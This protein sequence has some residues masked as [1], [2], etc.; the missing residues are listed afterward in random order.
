M[1]WL[2]AESAWSDLSRPD[3]D[4]LNPPNGVITSSASNVLTHTV[5]ARSCFAI[6]W[7]LPTLLV[8]TEA[9]NPYSVPF[10][11]SIACASS[12]ASIA[13]NTGPNISSCESLELCFTLS[14][15]AMI[16]YQLTKVVAWCGIVCCKVTRLCSPIKTEASIATR[17]TCLLTSCCKSQLVLSSLIP[18]VLILVHCT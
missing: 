5:P 8:Q 15:A 12:R 2:Y 17:K 14:I 16:N 3:P 18:E 11:N 4:D 1:S 10:A 9:A 13:T 6:R 7:A